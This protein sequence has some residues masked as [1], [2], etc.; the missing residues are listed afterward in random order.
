MNALAYLIF[1]KKK[2]KFI[3]S[4][5]LSQIPEYGTYN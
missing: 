5:H 4:Y 3:I 2:K 1:I